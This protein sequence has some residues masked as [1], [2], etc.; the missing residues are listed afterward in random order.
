MPAVKNK[1]LRPW[2]LLLLIAAVL[3]ALFFA[4]R[5]DKTL[6]IFSSTESMQDYIA[7]SGAWAPLVFIAVQILQVIAAP[8]PGNV[9]TLVGGA[10]FGFFPAMLYSVFAVFIGSMICFCLARTF[11]KPLVYRLIS[12]AIADKYLVVLAKQQRLTLALLFLFPFFPDDALCLLAGLTGYSWKWFAGMILLTR[13]WGL[14]FSALVGS[15]SLSMPLL[16]WMILIPA[17]GCIL[18]LSVRYGCRIED[19]LLGKIRSLYMK[20]KK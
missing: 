1:K 17:A 12:P 5:A 6:Q 9:T 7:S 4:L 11:G 10:L 8:I 14:I 20:S 3:I 2:F 16:G 19:Y 15:G 18:F 13:P